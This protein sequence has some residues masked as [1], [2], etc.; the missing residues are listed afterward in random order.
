[1]FDGAR[2][3]SLSIMDK[4][5]EYD[6]CGA[7]QLSENPHT[8]MSGAVCDQRGSY[9]VS[10]SWYPKTVAS[11]SKDEIA[12]YLNKQ[13]QQKKADEPHNDHKEAKAAQLSEQTDSEI[14]KLS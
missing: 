7:V 9:L 12:Q 8:K 13:E 3:C 2:C 5:I 6:Q 11:T 4:A 1:M 10:F 14:G